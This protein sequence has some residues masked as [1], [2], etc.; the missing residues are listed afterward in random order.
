MSWGF[1][2]PSTAVSSSGPGPG[3]E[4]LVAF[5]PLAVPAWTPREDKGGYST[6]GVGTGGLRSSTP[7]LPA[8]ISRSAMTVGL[9]LLASTSGVAPSAIW[10]ARL[11]AARVSSKRFGKVLM[12]SSTVMRAMVVLRISAEF[13]EQRGQADRLAGACEAR[14]AHH[15]NQVGKGHIEGFVDNYIFKFKNMRDVFA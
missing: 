10:R 14:G 15:G 2:Y 4:P 5:R 6:G 7:T 13:V 3:R 8:A 11:V 12:Q 1:R 9:S